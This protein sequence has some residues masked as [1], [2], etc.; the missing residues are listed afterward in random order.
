MHTL[1]L[2]EEA[3][4]PYYFRHYDAII[5]QY[6]FYDNGST[7][8][9][10]ELIKENPKA[11]VQSVEY[12]GPL[13][14][15]SVSQF[16]NNMWKI[17]R[18]VA[19][20]VV[21]AD[22]DEHLCIEDFKGYL[23][24]CDALGITVI[25]A[26]GYQMVSEDFPETDGRLCDLLQNGIPSS[27][28]SKAIIFN[29]NAVDEMLF[30]MGRHTAFPSGKVLYPSKREVKLLHYKYLGFDYTYNRNRYLAEQLYPMDKV[31]FLERYQWTPQRVR[32]EFV[33]LL[34]HAMNVF[35]TEMYSPDANQPDE[36][37]YID[38]AKALKDSLDLLT[39][40]KQKSRTIQGKYQADMEVLI[41]RIEDLNN[42]VKHLKSQLP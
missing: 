19:D 34:K 24:E 2:N 10:M 12:A 17:S 9:S 39:E 36:G 4:L 6:Y 22:V 16:V 3:L 33:H 8:K 29:P 42:Q 30:T 15:A 21:M 11:V 5:D 20:W 31:N 41:A 18:G 25:T 40:F 28:F 27:H 26:K 1:C 14:G 37:G 7:D 13:K 32:A 35:T 38:F 23:A